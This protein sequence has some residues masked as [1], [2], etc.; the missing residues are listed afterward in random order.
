M[1]SKSKTSCEIL[2]YE[3][4]VENV[5]KNDLRLVLERYNEICDKIAD[6]L[7]IRSV[8]KMI[9]ENKMKSMKTMADLGSNCYVKCLIPSTDHILLNVGLDCFIEFS[10]EEALKFIDK[11]SNLY[12]K[13][14]EILKEKSAKIK[15]H[16]KI[17][18]NLID[19][20]Q[21]QNL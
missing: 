4:F 12:N 17:V 9:T 1:D 15:A 20:L 21:N 5:L 14:L 13:S 2:K 18:L 10:I 7:K 19:Q 16:I 8:C 6:L 11:R 3:Q